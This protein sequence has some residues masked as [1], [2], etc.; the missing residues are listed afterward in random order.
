MT[1]HSVAQVLTI[2]T[3]LTGWLAHAAEPQRSPQA[4]AAEVDQ[5]LDARLAEAKIPSSPP[6]DDAEFLRRLSLDLRGRI[7]TAERALAF[8]N[9]NDPDKRRKL[10]DEFLADSAYGRHFGTIWYHRIVHRDD[11]NR[12]AISENLIDWLAK[13]FNDNRGWD[14][15]VADILTAEGERDLHPQTVF[16]LAHTSNKGKELD[17]P[18]ATAAASRLFL[19]VRLECCQCHNHPF[20]T[21]KQTDFWGMAAFFTTTHVQHGGKKDTATPVIHDSG[22]VGKRSRKAVDLPVAPNPGS[23][24]IPDTKNQ[25]VRA[26]VLGGRPTSQVAALRQGLASWTTSRQNPYFARAAVNKLWAN[27]FGRGFVNPV[28]DIRPESTNY[29]PDVLQL[30]SREFV[31]SGYDLKYLVRC[32]CNSRAYQRTSQPLSENKSDDVL[33]SHMLPKA[34][35]ADMLYD[36]LTV[37]LSHAPASKEARGDRK[38]K[39]KGLSSTREQFRHFFHAEADDDVGVVED[40]THGVPQVLRLMNAPLMNDSTVVVE[41]L[42]RDARTPEQVIEGLYLTTLSRRPTEAELG[43]LRQYVADSADAATGYRDVL[44]VLLNSA[45]FLFNH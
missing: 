29:H 42:M 6:A 5:L 2:A 10:I 13:S 4:V 15:I 41:G 36:S 33:Y 40:Y 35:N 37:A 38:N 19:G 23:I 14:R 24:V 26:T 17:I 16:W 3:A 45:E 20:T 27:F 39:K 11:D 43:R 30:L 22:T 25:V 7:P 31:A 12:Y 34:M 18:R 32:I 28:D 21:L 8:L 1:K 44:W 9:D